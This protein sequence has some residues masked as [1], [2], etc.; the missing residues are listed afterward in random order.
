MADFYDQYTTEFDT[1]WTARI[2]QQ[3]SKLAPYLNVINF[4]GEQKRYSRLGSVSVQ[5]RTVR[6]GPTPTQNATTDSRWA[7]RK[8]YDV[9]AHLIDRDEAENLGALTLP[10]SD[11]IR[12]HGWAY[13]RQFDKHVLRTAV[14]SVWTGTD[15]TTSTSFS[16]S[17]QIAHGSASLTVAKILQA[18]E[19]MATADVDEEMMP[20]WVCHPKQIT[21]LLN[22]TEVKSADYNTVKA[23]SEGKV[24]TFCGFKFIT[25]TQV[26]V[27][28]SVYYNV[29]FHPSALR[30]TRGSLKTSISTRSDLSDSLQLYSYFRLGGTRVHDEAVIEVACQN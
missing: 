9:P 4:D 5:E 17:Y 24:D 16:S 3:P 29:A 14:G 18:K 1:N 20:L 25:S 22:I 28:G 10:N 26:Y 2:Q 21:A 30:I 13:N 15:G 19:I 8:S 7:K 11:L 23:L 27:S 12:A 6:N